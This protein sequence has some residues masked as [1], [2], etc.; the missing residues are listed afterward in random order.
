M[1][2]VTS[3]SVGAARV[4][5][6]GEDAPIDTEAQL[7]LLSGPDGERAAGFRPARLRRFLL[8]RGLVRALVQERFPE[9][10]AWTV[11]PGECRCCGVRHAGVEIE[12]AP[13]RASVSYAD[14]IVVAAVADTARTHRLG[15]DV[16]LDAADQAR[17][18]DLR[19]L[20]GASSEAVLRRWTRVEA[21]LKADG[22]GLLIDPGAVWLRRGGA[23]IAGEAESY[24]VTD[25]AGPA[26]YLVSLAWSAAAAS[27]AEPGRATRRT[28]GRA[29]ARWFLERTR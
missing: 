25:V 3:V 23:W 13:A 18:D 19:R 4:A 27:A 22:R 28:A 26:G 5:W 29:G 11:Q 10:P 1:G 6:M 7:A 9:A 15:V 16:E 12:G 14:G 17:T 24:V 21:V 20:L 2:L 8:G